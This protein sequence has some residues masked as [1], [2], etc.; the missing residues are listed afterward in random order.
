MEGSGVAD[1]GT[2]RVSSHH[3]EEHHLSE[4]S[5][6]LLGWS[7]S[8]KSSAGNTILGRKEFQSGIRTAQCV[9]RQ[10]EVAGRQV[11]VVDTPGWGIT[12]S[13]KDTRAVVKQEIVR[14]VSLCPPGPYALFLVINVSSSF[15]ESH[16]R[17]VEEHL[18]LLSERVWRHTIVLFTRGDWLGDTTIEQHIETEGKALQWL[19]EKCGNRYHVL[20]NENRGD[21]TQVTELLEKIEETVARNR[22]GHFTIEESDEGFK[23]WFK[24]EKVDEKQLKQKFEEEWSRREEEWRR[25]EEELIERMAKV[26]VEETRTREDFLQCSC[27]LTLD[28]NTACRLLRLSEGNREVTCVRQDQPYPDHPE[29][30]DCWPQV[31][32]REGLSGRSYWEA[33]WGGGG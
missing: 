14:S 17:P 8:G 9:K 16:R 18:E 24:G 29:R 30:F 25:R 5:I 12:S 32:C 23:E 15:T 31:L 3:R 22:S 10:G 19:V 33:E 20:N 11:T 28:P 1:M 2:G 26:A 21:G 6:V 7:R 4:L 13:V 27:Q